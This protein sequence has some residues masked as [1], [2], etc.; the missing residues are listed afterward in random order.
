MRPTGAPSG[1]CF[2][3]FATASASLALPLRSVADKKLTQS[4]GVGVCNDFGRFAFIRREKYSD[5][6][7]AIPTRKRRPESTSVISPVTH[8]VT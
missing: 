5:F 3:L 1:H 6:Y 7:H 2:R 4:T 8:D